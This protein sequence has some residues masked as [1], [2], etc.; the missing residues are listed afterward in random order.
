MGSTVDILSAAGRHGTHYPVSRPNS[1]ETRDLFYP[2]SY[3]VW[4]SICFDHTPLV[5]LVGAVITFSTGLVA[6]TVAADLALAVRICTG[7]MTFATFLVLFTAIL[8]EV[9]E[10]RK[11]IRKDVEQDPRQPEPLMGV[12]APSYTLQ[13]PGGATNSNSNS[14]GRGLALVIILKSAATLFCTWRQQ[15]THLITRHFKADSST[16]SRSEHDSTHGIGDV[17]SSSR[18][19]MS[20]GVAAKD[21]VR[22]GSL[23]SDA[24]DAPDW[25]PMSAPT[26]SLNEQQKEEHHKTR[27][28]SS[29]SKLQGLVKGLKEDQ[30]PDRPDN[31]RARPDELQ[32][33]RP[34]RR[35]PIFHSAGHDIHFSPDGKRLAV[36]RLNGHLAIWEVGKYNE[37]PT[38]LRSPVGR[39]AWSPDSSHIVVVMEKGLKTWSVASVSHKVSGKRDY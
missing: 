26:Q 34:L 39:F 16:R 8:W 27:T 17:H 21:V 24:F 31:C 20:N 33:L 38:Q 15:L 5:C 30:A 36:S 23:A 29:R 2:V 3:L 25:E 9:R 37:K 1:D 14:R 4:A 35:L 32:S 6:W 28:E 13:L 7:T 11:E 19:S 10:R 18:V 22:E 12:P